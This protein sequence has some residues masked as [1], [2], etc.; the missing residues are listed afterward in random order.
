M[1]RDE[2]IEAV[3]V[4]TNNVKKPVELIRSRYREL[5]HRLASTGAKILGFHCFQC[6]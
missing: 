4:G 2:E 3:R 1:V 5:L 6:Y